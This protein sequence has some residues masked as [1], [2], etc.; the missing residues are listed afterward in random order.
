MPEMSNHISASYLFSLALQVRCIDPLLSVISLIKSLWIVEKRGI[1][2]LQK[3]SDIPVF[4]SHF[5]EFYSPAG[6]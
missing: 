1:D 6:T 3:I 2:F 4:H 5:L